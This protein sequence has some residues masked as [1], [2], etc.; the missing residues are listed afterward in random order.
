MNYHR[1]R[2]QLLIDMVESQ[3]RLIDQLLKEQQ[4]ENKLEYGWSG[5]LGR[6]YWDVQSNTVTFNPL[7]VQALGYSMEEIPQ[8]IGYD[9]FTSKLHPDDYPR[10]MDNMRK[11]LAG[12]THVYEVEYR[13]RAKDGHYCW[14]YDRGAITSRDDQGRPL[15]LVGI[16]FDISNRKELEQKIIEEKEELH[17]K[18]MTDELTGLLNLRGIMQQL[19]EWS[20]LSKQNQFPLSLLMIDIDDFKK[21]NDTYGHPVGNIVLQELASLLKQ[22]LRN[23]DLVG[24]YGGE[25]FLLIFPHT[26]L[27]QAK[28][29]ADRI[30]LEIADHP[31]SHH[32]RFTVSGGVYEFIGAT[33][34]DLINQADINLYEAKRQ[35]K[36]RIV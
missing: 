28:A 4:T 25:E 31:F 18:S 13:I 10:I 16:V 2:K 14:F 7:K 1:L 33:I 24:R 36:N 12:E 27:Q 23:D 15:L 11:H 20:S 30:R 22:Q 19:M 21:I 3:Q 6:W 29:I 26:T 32:I 9:F 17:Q 35:G 8:P 34:Y 5:N